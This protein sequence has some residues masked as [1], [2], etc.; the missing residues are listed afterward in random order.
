MT[1]GEIRGRLQK[2]SGGMD[3]ELID[4]WIQDRY[5][6]A[7]D[8]IPWKRLESNYTFQVP[9]SVTTGTLTVVAGS[10]TITGVGTTWTDALDGFMLRV[11][12]QEEYYQVAYV[13]PT[14]LTAD[15]GYERA[16]D[17]AL[18]YRIDQSLFVMPANARVIESLRPISG[19]PLER[20]ST[21]EMDRLAGNRNF[22]GDPR[23]F[24]ASW[25]NFEDPPR[26]QVELFP[27]P[28]CPDSLSR[29]LSFAVEL[30]VDAD[31]IEPEDTGSSLLPFMRSQ[32]LIA[33]VQSDIQAHLKDYGG[34]AGR[35]DQDA[36]GATLSASK[37][38]E[39]SEGTVALGVHRIG[40]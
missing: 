21:G 14:E 6:Q 9:A 23:A 2:L 31:E 37:S 20:K 30:V 39:V 26:L 15:R 16:S 5:A 35:A 32:L 19:F 40:L 17:S 29:Q 8:K 24:C 12:A 25:D 13:S 7:L 3:L 33:G 18:G 27:V 22:Y 10:T 28:N 34:A 38:I 11:D 36:N 4:G 1:Y